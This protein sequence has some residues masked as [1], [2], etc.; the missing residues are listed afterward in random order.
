MELRMSRSQRDLCI[1]RNYSLH[2]YTYTI[3]IW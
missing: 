1:C 3:N 2:T